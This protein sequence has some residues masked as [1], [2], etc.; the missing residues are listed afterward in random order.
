LA[1]RAVTGWFD[2]HEDTEIPAAISFAVTYAAHSMHITCPAC[3]ADHVTV[4]Y[5][6]E[7]GRITSLINDHIR[8]HYPTGWGQKW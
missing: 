8:T 2:R 4:G 1:S 3:N 7:Y 6:M 5:A